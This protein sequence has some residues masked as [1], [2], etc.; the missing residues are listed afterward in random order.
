MIMDLVAL[1]GHSEFRYF[2]QE[3]TVDVDFYFCRYHYRRMF[4]ICL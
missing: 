1:I 3:V 2:D 4:F